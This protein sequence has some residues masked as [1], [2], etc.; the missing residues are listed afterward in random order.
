MSLLY[1]LQLFMDVVD[2]GEVIIRQRPAGATPGEPVE[3]G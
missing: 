3:N 2:G 1:G